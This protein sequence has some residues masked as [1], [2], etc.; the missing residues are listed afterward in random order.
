M[1]TCLMQPGPLTEKRLPTTLWVHE[2]VNIQ[3]LYCTDIYRTFMSRS[4]IMSTTQTRYRAA[5][6]ARFDTRLSRSQKDLFEEA[7]R[8]KGFKSLSEFVIHTTQEAATI[9]IEK[10]NAV[11]ASERDKQVFFEALANPPSPNKALIQAAKSYQKV[12]TAK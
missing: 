10:H 8:I 2:R 12:V 7:A 11:L 5:A 3:L 1:Q 4:F 9:I 6:Q